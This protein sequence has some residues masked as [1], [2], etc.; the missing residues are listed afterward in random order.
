M[1]SATIRSRS[2]RPCGTYLASSFGR[3][4][5]MSLA[6]PSG[7]DS[8]LVD[9]GIAYCEFRNRLPSEFIAAPWGRHERKQVPVSALRI[10]DE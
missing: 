8:S 7:F 4:F 6:L 5:S 3:L 10:S 2:W 1:R 9:D